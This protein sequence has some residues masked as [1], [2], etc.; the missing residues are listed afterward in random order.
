M[1]AMTICTK[2]TVAAKTWKWKHE[3]HFTLVSHNLLETFLLVV[4]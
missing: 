4:A 2:L 3:T 1:L